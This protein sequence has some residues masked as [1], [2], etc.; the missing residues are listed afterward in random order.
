M[1]R[2]ARP[3]APAQIQ[4]PAVDSASPRRAGTAQPAAPRPGSLRRLYRQLLRCQDA[5][6]EAVG[7]L[8]NAATG[9]ATAAALDRR[10]RGLEQE[11]LARLC[12][13]CQ[14]RAGQPLL[15][16]LDL[17]ADQ[18]RATTAIAAQVDRAAGFVR[19]L[20]GVIDASR[21]WLRFFVPNR[22]QG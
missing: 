9:L 1:V 13:A 10:R 7:E 15:A 8:V 6:F 4:P 21:N 22:D 18:E 12:R 3:P 2:A 14:R 19:T 20:N 17:A 11:G 5:G 16:A